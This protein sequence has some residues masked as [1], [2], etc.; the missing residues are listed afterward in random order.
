MYKWLSKLS[1]SHSPNIKYKAVDGEERR[2]T[3]DEENEFEQADFE[4]KL[5]SARRV[6]LFLSLGMGLTSL[7][8]IYV[9]WETS[10]SVTKATPTASNARL[11][12]DQSGFYLDD[13]SH[14]WHIDDDLFSNIDKVDE[15]I[16]QLQSIHNF[17]GKY[18]TWHRPD[19]STKGLPAYFTITSDRQIY[20]IRGLH[21]L[22]C[23]IDLAEMYGAA[24]HQVPNQWPAR[25]FSH[26]LNVVR[27]AVMC[28]ADA[29]PITY[30][31][32][33]L[34]GVLTDDQQAYCRDFTALRRW[35]NDPVRGV[36]W[37]NI[38]SKGDTED[39][40][41]DIIPFP[42]LNEAQKNGLA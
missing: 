27:E 19:G 30:V 23:I 36:R 16:R 31:N 32:G 8:L 9:I 5:I 29:T 33:F 41:T 40:W 22:H 2:S 11:G 37:K 14:P 24:Y 4:A 6:I 21:Q 12:V 1:R 42:E 28:L 13:H 38:R 10:G 17:N 3:S 7:A 39:K 35:A 20:S 25:H 15:K 18:S 26:C 34:A